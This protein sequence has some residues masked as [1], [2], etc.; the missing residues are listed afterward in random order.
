M[1]SEALDKLAPALV[2]AQASFPAIKKTKKAVYGKYADLASIMDAIRK[3][4]ADNGLSVTQDA[5]GTTGMV[6]VTT[7]IM[8]TS[9]QW[10]ESE[11]LMLPAGN[12]AQKAGA[13]LTY[14]R[15]YSLTAALG[16]AA[17]EDDDGKSA[18]APTATRSGPAEQRGKGTTPGDGGGAKRK[19]ADPATTPGAEVGGVHDG[20]GGLWTDATASRVKCD[21]CGN[22]EKKAA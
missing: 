12:D 19:P 10:L 5:C 1:H 17:D 6:G 16:I 9:G 13:A 11:P 8:H 4:L 20:C 15:R 14:A 7:R 22:T 3:P 2:A 21:T 18:S